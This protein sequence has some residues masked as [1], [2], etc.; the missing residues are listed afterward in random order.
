[1]PFLQETNTLHAKI[2]YRHYIHKKILL[3]YFYKLANEI[4]MKIAFIDEVKYIQ[5]IL[6]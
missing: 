1:M 6:Q 5:E 4:K 3:S 2:A